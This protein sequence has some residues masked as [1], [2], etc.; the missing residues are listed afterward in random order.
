[1]QTV[2]SNYSMANI[3]DFS[4]APTQKC[5][6]DKPQPWANCYGVRCTVENKTVAGKEQQIAHCVCP[7]LEDKTFLIGAPEQSACAKKDVIWSATTGDTMSSFG[8]NPMV[9]L[10]QKIDP[11]SPPIKDSKKSTE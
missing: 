10:Y 4:A 5:N 1:L 11:Q 7:V 3:S 9:L 6:Y 2:Q 8:A